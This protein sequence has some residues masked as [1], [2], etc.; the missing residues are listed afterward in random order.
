MPTTNANEVQNDT[1]NILRV[2]AANAEFKMKDVTLESLQADAE[3]LRGLMQEIADK[4]AAIMPLRNHRDDLAGKMN[5]V[6]TRAR[7][8]MKGYFGDDS[9]QYE[10]AG[11]TRASERKRAG[12]RARAPVLAVAK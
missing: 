8:G 7:A 9:S 12:P 11:G 10:L 4:E 5:S 3:T 1:T 6:N 2:W